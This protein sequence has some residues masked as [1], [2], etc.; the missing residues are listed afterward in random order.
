M[1]DNQSR[2]QSA[3]ISVFCFFSITGILGQV[4]RAL[5]TGPDALP[6]PFYFEQLPLEQVCLKQ[7]VGSIRIVLPYNGPGGTPR[8]LAFSGRNLPG[9]SCSL[10]T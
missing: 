9:R 10:Q 2:E 3:S 1:W 7:L 8:A 6:H 5:N 4:A